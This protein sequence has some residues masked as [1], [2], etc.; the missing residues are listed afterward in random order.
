MKNQDRKCL[1]KAIQPLLPPW[2]NYGPTTVTLLRVSSN[3]GDKAAANADAISAKL[4]HRQGIQ[5]LEEVGGAARVVADGSPGARLRKEHSVRR[6][7]RRHAHANADRP[8]LQMGWLWAGQDAKELLLLIHDSAAQR[9][10]N[11]PGD[12][13][14]GNAVVELL[15]QLIAHPQVNEIHFGDW[16]RV[17]R[18][19]QFGARVLAAA[20]Q[21]AVQL[22][23]GRQRVDITSSAGQF[24]TQ[25]KNAMSSEERNQTRQRTTRGVLG[26][27]N[28]VEAAWPYAEHM[29]PPGYALGDVHREETQNRRRRVAVIV[30]AI[31]QAQ[32]WTE[33][34]RAIAS[35]ARW[36][37]VG[38]V[39]AKHGLPCR[40]ARLVGKTYDTLDDRQLQRAARANA[41]RWQTVR[42]RKYR[43]I[44]DLPSPID[45][46]ETFEGYEVDFSLG[47]FGGIRLEVDL[48][49]S[50]IDLTAAEWAAIERRMTVRQSRQ[51]VS[52][53]LRFALAGANRWDE[54]DI[55]Y[56]VTVHGSLPYAYYQVRSRPIAESRDV[57]GRERGWRSDEGSLVVSVPAKEADAA[58]GRGIESATMAA[59]G[60]L[61]ALPVV[62]RH[63]EEFDAQV[64]EDRRQ[65]RLREVSSRIA[66]VECDVEDAQSALDK[67][68]NE[69]RARRLATAEAVLGEL[70]AE[71]DLL[72]G[73]APSVE[74]ELVPVADDEVAAVDVSTLAGL[75]GILQG[76]PGKRL[77]RVVND[78]I[79]EVTSGS[80]RLHARP[81]NPW[82]AELT[83]TI[84]WPTADGRTVALSICEPVHTTYREGRDDRF[85]RR[86]AETI[87]SEGCSLD[88]AA[89]LM[90]GSDCSKSARD[91]LGRAVTGWIVREKRLSKRLMRALIDCPIPETKAI[92]WSLINGT[93]LPD[94]TAPEFAALLRD[95][96]LS[97]THMR[98]GGFASW[99]GDVGL[100]RTALTVFADQL[101]RGDGID[102]GIHSTDLAELVAATSAEVMC[103]A[104]TESSDRYRYRRVLDNHADDHRVLIPRRCGECGSLLLHAIRTPEVDG[105]VCVS[106]SA[107]ETGVVL[108][109]AYLGLWDGG[110]EGTRLGDPAEYRRSRAI[111]GKRRLMG[112]G[113]ASRVFNIPQ[114]KLR[115]LANMGVVPSYRPGRGA[116]RRFDPRDLEQL[117]RAHASDRDRAQPDGYMSINEAAAYLNVNDWEV[118]ALALSTDEADGPLRYTRTNTG[119]GP[120]RIVVLVK[121]LDQLDGDWIE[122]RSPHRRLISWVVE[123][124]GL[125]VSVIREATLRGELPALRATGT[126][127]Y[128]PS[129]VDMWMETSGRV[130]TWHTPLEAA[131][132]AG[133]TVYVIDGAIKRGE[134]PAG[135]TS[136]G[137]R[138][139]DPVELRAWVERRGA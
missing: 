100:A 45:P 104:G 134:L 68:P 20:R 126:A 46:G 125:S 135:K 60:D 93:P 95:T 103:L 99:S 115:N 120:L 73:S 94:G 123:R 15:V 66:E 117:A 34:F 96:Y 57:D 6:I 109:R 35:G 37:D 90:L 106:C 85:P 64:E 130:L 48:P 76:A 14:A 28:R 51:R 119:W 121:D 108:P 27:L 105:L 50:G 72:M 110:P 58:F 16:S 67:N 138:R 122:A 124:T 89:N 84:Y 113:E 133:V 107:T 40:G 56:A 10:V 38:R 26:R 78:R 87:L 41:V 69:H 75:A 1:Y 24:T 17:V 11:L 29:L 31:E 9:N 47:E 71:K 63:P 102:E 92:V 43:A 98:H 132:A 32:A 53:D 111:P 129:E 88:E 61:A 52:D 55:S 70:L 2:M 39:L 13:L 131:K 112:I 81:G 137:H 7:E 136:G 59:L 82:V 65:D 54:A 91:G 77:P 79:K 114:S 5:W 80:I 8:G 101:A 23:E 86:A 3:S 22:F 4:G 97:G 25:I 18:D 19:T 118:R 21:E 49:D 74:D 83:A 30:P 36:K 44:R 33:F 128:L 139:I 12:I 42:D 116:F 62:T 127:K